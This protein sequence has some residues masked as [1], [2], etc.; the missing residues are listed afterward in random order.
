[1]ESILHFVAR[2]LL[3]YVLEPGYVCRVPLVQDWE[4]IELAAGTHRTPDRGR[5]QSAQAPSGHEA[6][7]AYLSHLPSS[8]PGPRLPGAAGSPAGSG[9]A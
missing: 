6:G 4:R 1:M 2:A 7:H 5:T 3:G 9:T 8:D